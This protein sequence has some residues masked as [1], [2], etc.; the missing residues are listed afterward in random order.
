MSIEMFTF[1]IFIMLLMVGFGIIAFCVELYIKF[2]EYRNH[3]RIM[4]KV[5]LR[6]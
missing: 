5:I 4:N 1:F 6:K 3:K 2:Q